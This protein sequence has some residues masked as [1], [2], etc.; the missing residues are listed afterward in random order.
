MPATSGSSK[1]NLKNLCVAVMV[2]LIT[3]S[4]LYEN[5]KTCPD[6]NQELK[7]EARSNSDSLEEVSDEKKSLGLGK[8]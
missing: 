7:L 6:S 8:K 2:Q 3:D 4:S 5:K 1:E